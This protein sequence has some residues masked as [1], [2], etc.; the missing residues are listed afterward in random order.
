MKVKPTHTIFPRAFDEAL[1]RD[2]GEIL[3]FYL[4]KPYL[5]FFGRAAARLVFCLVL[6]FFLSPALLPRAAMAGETITWTG[7][8]P[9]FLQNITDPLL[10]SHTDSVAPQNSNT[11]SSSIEGNEITIDGNVP[12]SVFGAVNMFDSEAVTD[13][14]VITKIGRNV[15]G[16]VIGGLAGGNIVSATATGNSVTISGNMIGDRVIGGW[17]ILLQPGSATASDNAVIITD[18]TAY[19]VTGGAAEVVLW[20]NSGIAT[21]SGNT[22]TI[23]GNSSVSHDVYGGKSFSDG[24]ASV[25]ANSNT[26]NI[27]INGTVGLNVYGGHAQTD[28]GSATTSGNTATISGGTV[29]RNVYGGWA[30]SVSGTA[31]ASGNSVTISGGIF[32]TDPAYGNIY[33]GA[34]RSGSASAS[35][36][37]TD[38]IVTISGGTG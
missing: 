30:Q 2:G 19:S 1:P 14:K 38:N 17:A 31:T 10:D 32:G 23:S 4:E 28:S 20:P 7:T 21:T 6:A 26:V 37:A 5:C 11:Q 25:T 18:S 29:N 13:N 24:G 16:S 12:G 8:P 36:T 15:G 22:A 34:V 33:G 27:S 35:V 3:P 9:P